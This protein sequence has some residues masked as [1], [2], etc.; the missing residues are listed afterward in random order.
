MNSFD[1]LASKYL[2]VIESSLKNFLN[3][4]DFCAE[5][6]S[7]HLSTGGKR[8]RALIPLMV[9][10]AF[11]VD[12]AR[13]VPI[14]AAVEM[15]HNATLVHDDLQDG[16]Q[17]RR[18]SPTVWMKYSEAQAINCG[19]A[20]FFYALQMI[21]TCDFSL[22]CKFQIQKLAMQ[23][24]LAVIEGQAQEFKMKQEVMPNVARYLKVIK[25][26]TSGLFSLPV[27]AALLATGFDQQ[28]ISI[29]EKVAHDLGVIFQI[30]DDLIDIYGEKNRGQKASDIAEGKISFLVAQVNQVASQGDK[31]VLAH[32]LATP[33]AK[34]SA[35][36]IDSALGIFEKYK[37]REAATDFIEKIKAEISSSED[38]LQYP[39]IHQ[40]LLELSDLFFR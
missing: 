32:I 21:D 4:K 12:P 24:T 13:A 16:D 14:G 31:E 6:A 40:V 1:C 35:V 30:Q 9:F 39:E 10:D 25:G 23:A 17:Q 11:G 28:K 15:I 27:A 26:K 38:L 36:Q 7:Y 20:M 8:I 33:R 29:G 34:T 19:D 22:D 37:A 2:S 18:G 5:M 3:E